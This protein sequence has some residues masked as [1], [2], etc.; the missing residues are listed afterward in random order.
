MEL[1]PAVERRIWS[2]DSPGIQ[3]DVDEAERCPQAES[4]KVV[5]RSLGIE[6]SDLQGDLHNFPG[7]DWSLWQ[8]NKKGVQDFATKNMS[9]KF[10]RLILG[11]KVVEFSIF[12][13][14]PICPANPRSGCDVMRIDFPG[15]P[16]LRGS[17]HPEIAKLPELELLDLDDS[18]VSGSLDVLANNTRLEYLELRNTRVVGWLEHLSKAELYTLDLTGTEV[19]GDL[20]ALANATELRYLRLSNTAVFGDLKSL[21]KM[22]G[23]KKLV[24]TNVKVVGDA[25]AMAEW[26]KIQH[27]DLSG[28]Q[29]KFVKTD[30]PQEFLAWELEW[31]CAWPALRF[32]D[33]SMTPQFSLAHNLLRLFVG[34]GKL[35]TLKA[36]GCGL[37]GP[38]WPEIISVWG[39]GESDIFPVD[40][41]PLSQALSVLDLASNNVTEVSKLPGSCRTLVLA[42]NPHVS[43][44]PGVLEKAIRDIVFVNLRNATFANL[45]DPLLLIGQLAVITHVLRSIVVAV[46]TSCAE[47]ISRSHTFIRPKFSD[48]IR[49]N[50]L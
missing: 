10:V 19:T 50:G 9:E 3:P 18:N 2:A 31:K 33:V 11:Q 47:S 38:L 45:S 23:L 20:A 21:A 5:L 35:A 46:V 29:V 32:L 26:S 4:L 1:S 16:G 27:V 22:K 28:T 36:T 43:F 30:F 14:V 7:V 8:C 13:S 48:W 15:R 41:W 44:G 6:E 40:A 17:L 42:G 49:Q 12:A 25:A 37:R 24:L 39:D 34:C